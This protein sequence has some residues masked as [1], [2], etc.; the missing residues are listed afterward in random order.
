VEEAMASHLPVIS[1][2]SAGDIRSRLPE[3][4]AGYVVATR[5]AALLGDRMAG[6]AKDPKLRAQM[7]KAAA[8][9]VA[10]KSHE[11]YAEDFER[12]V[13]RVLSMPRVG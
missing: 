6:L 12:F 1:S 3:G 8:S 9:I 13:E 10:T 4:V 2:D 7:G 11:A 5:D